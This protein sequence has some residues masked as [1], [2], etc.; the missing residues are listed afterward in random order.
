MNKSM[1][2]DIIL[3]LL[4]TIL[5]ASAI[6][7]HSKAEEVTHNV[8]GFKSRFLAHVPYGSTITS[9]ERSPK[10]CKVDGS[11]GPDCCSNKCVNLQNDPLNCGKCGKKCGSNKMCCEGKCVNPMTNEK[12]CGK[13]GHKCESASSCLY[14]MCSYA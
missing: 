9:C 7:T 13:C 8:G 2:Y 14:G 6:I 5:A 10:A 4:I 1:R 11:P 12:H 3:F